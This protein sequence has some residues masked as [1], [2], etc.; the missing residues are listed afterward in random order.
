MTRLSNYLVAVAFALGCILPATAF[1]DDTARDSLFNA[2]QKMLNAR[3]VADTVSTD[4][5]GRETTSKVEFDTINRFRATTPATSFVVL[6]EGTW[7]RSG[8]GEWT[9]PPIDMS[10]MIKHL[11]P[12][13]LEDVRAGTSNIKDEGTK[14]INGQ[15]ARVISYD[16]NT[17]IMN[18]NVSSH[19]TVFIDASGHIVRSESDSTAMGHTSHSVQTI[20]YDDSVRITAPN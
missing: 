10:A 15:E 19:N 12:A 14:S 20:R 6:P 17:K 8:K 1:A 2:Y 16:V 9:Q 13:A 5:K 11:V 18:F 4:A 7:M 3:Y